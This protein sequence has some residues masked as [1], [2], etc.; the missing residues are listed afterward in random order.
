MDEF[1]Q[2]C[3]EEDG[4]IPIDREWAWPQDAEK[5]EQAVKEITE[6]EGK[7]PDFLAAFKNSGGRPP[8]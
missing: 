3:S 1:R 6:R 5:L 4:P 8:S 7:L 2:F